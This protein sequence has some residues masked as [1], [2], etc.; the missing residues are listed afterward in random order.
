VINGL[1]VLRSKPCGARVTYVHILGVTQSSLLCTCF[2]CS[3]PF[4]FFIG[5]VVSTG[6]NGHG[7]ETDGNNRIAKPIASFMLVSDSF[8]MFQSAAGCRV[9]LLSVL[10]CVTARCRALLQ[11]ATGYCSVQ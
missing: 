9:L 5:G 7:L 3:F 8:I 11:C 2:C 10:H 1:G 4:S 6:N